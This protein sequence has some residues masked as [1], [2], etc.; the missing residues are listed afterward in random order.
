MPPNG[1]RLRLSHVRGSDYSRSVSSK[2]ARSFRA[3]E[4]CRSLLSPE[5]RSKLKKL[6]YQRGNM[7]RHHPA[8]RDQRFMDGPGG[9][10]RQRRGPG[11]G[12]SDGFG[13]GQDFGPGSGGGPDFDVEIEEEMEFGEAHRPF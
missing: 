1:R 7:F 3:R 9:E 10:R 8:W 5:Q 12:R 13:P 6:H 2:K 11:F 4:G